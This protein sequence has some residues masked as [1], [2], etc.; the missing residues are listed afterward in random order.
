MSIGD[1]LHGFLQFR[2]NQ[3]SARMERKEMKRLY[4]WAAKNGI[5]K[6]AVDEFC[7][8][9]RDFEFLSGERVRFYNMHGSQKRNM[10]S[11]FDNFIGVNDE[12]VKQM[13][14]AKDGDKAIMEDAYRLMV[15]HEHSHHV[16]YKD[17]FF[18][19]FKRRSAIDYTTEVYADVNGARLAFPD[20]PERAVA[21]AEWIKG[22]ADPDSLEDK[23]M[24]PSWDHRLEF[25]RK[26]RFDAD[27]IR[28]AVE[29]AG[30]RPKRVAKLTADYQSEHEFFSAPPR[31][32]NTGRDVAAASV[33]GEPRPVR[34]REITHTAEPG[35]PTPKKEPDTHRDA[36]HRR[37]G[38]GSR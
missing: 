16:W 35:R 17:D 27:T 20:D 36:R 1:A 21:A 24:H 5:D 29:L 28:E 26:G 23:R 15:A 7:N 34:D 37:R 12:W 11:F 2:S 22:T 25:I 18:D 10:N 38:R 6:E 13:L 31:A 19:G 3:R 33:I 30:G 14:L 9:H 8:S 32:A 4:K